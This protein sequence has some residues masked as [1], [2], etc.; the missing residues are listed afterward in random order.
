M[1]L[2]FRRTLLH[3]P[4][5]EIER[6]RDVLSCCGIEFSCVLLSFISHYYLCIWVPRGTSMAQMST[7]LKL[8]FITFSVLEYNEYSKKQ[9]QSHSRLAL[10]LW[11][12]YCEL[13]TFSPR[14]TLGLLLTLP[15]LGTQDSSSS[16]SSGM[17]PSC[18][19]VECSRVPGRLWEEALYMSIAYISHYWKKIVARLHF[20]SE[21]EKWLNSF[22][23]SLYQVKVFVLVNEFDTNIKK[24]DTQ[25]YRRSSEPRPPLTAGWFDCPRG[26]TPVDE[27]SEWASA[28]V[29]VYDRVVSRTKIHSCYRKTYSLCPR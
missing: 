28:I 17:Q 20:R 23:H 14:G 26:A 10:M 25:I 12:L 3:I 8:L 4:N 9:S 16:A 27:E 1:C 29:G 21:I 2:D 5:P 18:S 7:I 11:E 24:K 19:F 15:M 13:L 6:W 22:L